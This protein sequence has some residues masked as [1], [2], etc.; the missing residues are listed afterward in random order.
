LKEIW[1]DTFNASG[2]SEKEELEDR[3][4][5]LNKSGGGQASNMMMVVL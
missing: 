1:Q 4:I 3:V 5:G 2:Q